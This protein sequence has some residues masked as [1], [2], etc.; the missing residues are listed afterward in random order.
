M[1]AKLRYC[2]RREGEEVEAPDLP[3]KLDAPE[4]I[5]NK[6]G[7]NSSTSNAEEQAYFERLEAEAEMPFD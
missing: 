5:I 3:G 7:K 1:N 6:S 2:V 4:P